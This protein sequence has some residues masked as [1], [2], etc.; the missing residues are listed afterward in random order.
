MPP[1]LFADNLSGD[2]TPI[3]ITYSNAPAVT[4]RI[5]ANGSRIVKVSAKN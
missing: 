2:E 3:E 5:Y 4:Y 1:I